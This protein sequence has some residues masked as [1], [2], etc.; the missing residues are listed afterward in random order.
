MCLLHIAPSVWNALC[1][2][3]YLEDS[4][5]CTWTQSEHQLPQEALSD[6]SS[7]ACPTVHCPHLIYNKYSF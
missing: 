1:N 3:F 4:P 5:T 6:L 7:W 2:H